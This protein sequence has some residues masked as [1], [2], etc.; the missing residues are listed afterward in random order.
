LGALVLRTAPECQNLKMVG[1]AKCK[2]FPGSAVKGLNI[3]NDNT[4]H[5]I[6]VHSMTLKWLNQLHWTSHRDES[7]ATSTQYVHCRSP[8]DTFHN[9]DKIK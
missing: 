3:R 1:M 9:T 8:T 2:S 4:S 6:P 7:P 5:V